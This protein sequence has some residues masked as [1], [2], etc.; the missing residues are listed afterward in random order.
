MI[1]QRFLYIGI[2][3]SGLDIGRELSDAMT[4]EICGLDGR[5]LVAR[6]GPFAGFDRGQLPGFI[7]S[8]YLDF[9]SSALDEI[10][11]HLQGKNATAVTNI[12]P[13]ARLKLA[14]A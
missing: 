8:L 7:Q 2:C 11:T 10:K 9:S 12:L 4:K 14:L 13:P 6:G 1:R 5:R 3:G